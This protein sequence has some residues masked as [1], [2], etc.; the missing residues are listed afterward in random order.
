[1]APVTRSQTRRLALQAQQAAEQ[2]AALALQAQQQ[3]LDEI[4]NQFYTRLCERTRAPAHNILQKLQRFDSVLTYVFD[5]FDMYCLLVPTAAHSKECAAC[6]RRR[7]NNFTVIL[8]KIEEIERTS[9]T[10]DFIQQVEESTDSAT[11]KDLLDHIQMISTP[12]DA[13]V[14]AQLAA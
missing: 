11:C 2:Q 12:L 10:A 4:R 1:M 7:Q 8:H 13:L 9:K 6:N 14:R 3:D 5:H